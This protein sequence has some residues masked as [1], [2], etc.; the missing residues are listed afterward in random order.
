MLLASK[1]PLRALLL[2]VLALMLAWRGDAAFVASGN[3][4]TKAVIDGVWWV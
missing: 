2:L 3:D 4:D 1:D